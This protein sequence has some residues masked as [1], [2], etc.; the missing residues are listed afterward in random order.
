MQIKIAEACGRKGGNSATVPPGRYYCESLDAM[1]E[2]LKTLEGMDQY[3]YIEELHRVV[4]IANSQ[5]DC[6]RSKPT[7]FATPL[8][9]AE[10]F[11]RA[12]GLW[13]EMKP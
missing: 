8:Q 9:Q 6:T 11:L 4:A 12:K 13:E 1:A 5:P 2:A 3:R 10:A 7:E